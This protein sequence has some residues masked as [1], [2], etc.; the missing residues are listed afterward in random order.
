MTLN[1]GR[2]VTVLSNACCGNYGGQEHGKR[3]RSERRIY[4]EGHGTGFGVRRG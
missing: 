3:P 4:E 1:S 2:S